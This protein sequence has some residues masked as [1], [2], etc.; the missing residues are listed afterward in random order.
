M[1]VAPTPAEKIIPHQVLLLRKHSHHDEC[2]QVNAFTEHPEVVT[3]HQVEMDKLRHFAAHLWGR[4]SG[5]FVY[6]IYMWSKSSSLFQ[7]PWDFSVPHTKMCTP[8]N[9]SYAVL[10]CILIH[11]GSQVINDVLSQFIR[12]MWYSKQ[13]QTK[14]ISPSA[15]WVSAFLMSSSYY[16]YLFTLNINSR[17]IH[18]GTSVLI[19]VVFCQNNF[20]SLIST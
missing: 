16:L 9:L 7:K 13:F 20:D 8:G 1:T 4:N 5:S 11:G 6:E 15:Y 3:A 18:H 2:G 10:F 17:H 19:L 14:K 12:I